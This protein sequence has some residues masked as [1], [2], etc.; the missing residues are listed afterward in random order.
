[1]IYLYTLPGINFNYPEIKNILYSSYLKENGIEYKNID[2]TTFL[3][4]NVL[5]NKNFKKI[6][7]DIDSIKQDIKNPKKDL[8]KVNEKFLKSTN[9]FLIQFGLN[10]NNHGFYYNNPIKDINDLIKTSNN[11]KKF[12]NLFPLD[13]YKSKDI[14]FINVSY[15]FQIPMAINL[16]DRIKNQNKETKI[17]WGGNFLTQIN[18]NC[19]ELISEIKSL[20]AI[21][22][23][24]HLKTFKNIIDYYQGESNELLNA[25]TKNNQS[26]LDRNI[27]DDIKSYNLDYSDIDLEQYLSRDRILP[28]ILSYG[29]YY[30]NCKFCAHHYHY[31]NYQN[32]D[33]TNI[34][35]SIKKMYQENKFDSIVFLDEC[36]LPKKVIQLSEYLLENNIKTKWMFETRISKEYLD[37]NNVKKLK[38]SGCKFVSFGIESYN[39]NVLRNM[40]KGID[41]KIIKKVLK[42][43]YINNIIVSGTFIIG[44]P[45][46]TKLNIFKTL[47]F[48][49]HFK[50]IDSFG[51]NAFVLAR[52]SIISDELKLDYKNINLTYRLKDDYREYLEN[53]IQKFNQKK[54]IKKNAKV[55]NKLLNRC[56]Y[57]YLERAAF[58]INYKEE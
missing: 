1:M 2:Y 29:C 31:G 37:I 52:N 46:E 15:G 18:K 19:K 40:N 43:F 50:Y 57:F 55:K 58:S 54:K 5:T 7:I 30:N 22:F 38:D 16:S 12:I 44:Y 13:E 39:K 53:K 8:L 10:I 48:I 47:N 27:K 20:D 49:S 51:L 34:C 56:D 36:I 26:I 9:K 11:I 14:I 33:I 25:F 4:N 42:N 6:N 17:I 28:I 32:I 23:F 35:K 41:I 45:Q 24:N 3:L 21:I